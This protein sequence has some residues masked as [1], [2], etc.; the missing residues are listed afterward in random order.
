MLNR[1]KSTTVLSDISQLLLHIKNEDL[2]TIDGY[3]GMISDTAIES[4]THLAEQHVEIVLTLQKKVK[5]KILILEL[6][7]S[8]RQATLTYLTNK[9]GHIMWATSVHN[10]DTAKHYRDN[11]AIQ[12]SIVLAINSQYFPEPRPTWPQLYPTPTVNNSLSQYLNPSFDTT[13]FALKNDN[14]LLRIKKI[15][16]RVHDKPSVEAIVTINEDSIVHPHQGFQVM[17]RGYPA[18]SPNSNESGIFGNLF[19]I[20]FPNPLYTPT[21]QEPA[22]KIRSV[23]MLE[24]IDMY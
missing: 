20:Y 19:G 17:H 15:E 4:E 7:P 21:N 1:H 22:K 24:Y 8:N 13:E 18:P 23:A 2:P 11:I 9:L 12:R 3:Y 6:T 10:V 16:E 14:N 5:L